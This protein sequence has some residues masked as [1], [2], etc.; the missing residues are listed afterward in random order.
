MQT[1]YAGAELVAEDYLAGGL[2]FYV[3]GQYCLEL[4]HDGVAVLRLELV[5]ESWF[6]PYIPGIHCTWRGTHG[7]GTITLENEVRGTAR[8]QLRHST[9]QAWVVV[10]TW[11]GDAPAPVRVLRRAV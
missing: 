1:F 4:H 6:E 10:E 2:Y 5:H 11:E 9:D 3:I 8:A 7:A